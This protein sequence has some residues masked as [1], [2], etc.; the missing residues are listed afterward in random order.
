MALKLSELARCIDCRLQ[1][2]DCLIENVA[3]INQAD[4]GYLAFVYNPKYLA[5][6]KTSKAS[7]VII[8]EEWLPECDKPA[9]VSDN[10]RLAFAKAAILLNPVKTT[11]PVIS[12]TAVI[13]SSTVLTDTV[14]I[15]HNAVLHS[16]VKLGE[17]VQIGACTVIAEDV[18][19]G[20]NV[21]I[22]PNVSIGKGT[23]IGNGC[24]IYS[25]VVIG[26]DGFGYVK[27]GKTYLKVPQIG[28]VIIGNNV[29]IGANTT[30]DRGAL[31]DTIIHEGVKLDNQIQVAHNV[32]IGEHTVISACAA[33]GGSAKIGA[34][35]LIGG[36]VGIRDNIEIVDNVV[37]TGRSFISSSIK[38][39][40]SYSS[41]MLIDTTAHWRKNATRFKNLDNMAKRLKKLEN[42]S[43]NK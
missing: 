1:G 26:T 42:K 39:P 35:C 16:D 6:I 24:T 9:L 41:S 13:S 28:N 18:E 38:E 5:S 8:K 7:A 33:I 2:D 21:I 43:N 4:K 20:D 36:A 14:S 37:I 10:P 31:L 32:E 3:D 15:G 11:E 34:H 23:Q 17:N 25:G 22:Y 29:D 27:Q 12:E 40:G 30:V 19:I